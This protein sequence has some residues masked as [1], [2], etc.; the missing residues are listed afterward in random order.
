MLLLVFYVKKDCYAIDS[1]NVEEIVPL[2]TLQSI[3]KAPN[4]VA[5]LLNYHGISVPVIDLCLFLKEKK[6]NQYYNSRIIIVN[7]SSNYGKGLLGLIAENVTDVMRQDASKFIPCSVELTTPTFFEEIVSN[8]NGMIQIIEL[9]KLIT[10][11]LANLLFP[12]QCIK[13]NNS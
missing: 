7:Y 12:E 5:G 13:R 8:E 3:A 11:E 2:L 1:A 9:Q 10:N 4:F 6:S